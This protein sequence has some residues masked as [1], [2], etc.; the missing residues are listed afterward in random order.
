MSSRPHIRSRA[1]RLLAVGL[2]ASAIAGAALGA[3]GLALAQVQNQ[4]SEIRELE[5]QLIEVE[6]QASQAAGAHAQAEAR[7]GE[8]RGEIAEN[9]RRI[10]Q[11]RKAR[12]VAQ[13]RLA[14]RLVALYTEPQPTFVQLLLT[15]GDLGS[16]V[17]AQESL[18]TIG[19]ADRGIIRSAREGGIESVRLVSHILPRSLAHE[20]YVTE[21]RIDLGRAEREPV[22]VFAGSAREAARHFPRHF[23]VAVAL[24]LAG[25]GLDRTEI[26]IH[27]D[28]RIPGAR[29][30]VHVKSAAVE[31]EMTS[32]NFPSPENNRTSR[33]VAPSILAALREIGSPVRVGS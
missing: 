13:G 20:D 21:R 8:L 12:T 1:R 6:S 15:S 24:S 14:D 2:S 26:E 11:A 27:A 32:Q 33:I 30:T 10:R 9:A 25:I 28:G 22:P 16:A 23:N 19:L 3:G 7:V 5:A 29:H 18:E 31:L 17:E 4:R